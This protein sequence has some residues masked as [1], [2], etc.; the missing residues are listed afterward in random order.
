MAITGNKLICAGGKASPAWGD[1]AIWWDETVTRAAGVMLLGDF[2]ITDVTKNVQFGFDVNTASTIS[3]GVYIKTDYYRDKDNQTNL[4]SVTDATEYRFCVALTATGAHFFIRDAGTWH[5]LGHW[6]SDSNA[7]LY[8]RIANYDAAWS[9]DNIVVPSNIN[10]LPAPTLS[11]GFGSAFGTSDGLGHAEGVAG[12]VGSG[13]SGVTWVEPGSSAWAISTGEATNTPPGGGELLTDGDMEDDPAT[14]WTAQNDAVLNNFAEER[15]GGAGAQSLEVEKGAGGG[16]SPRAVQETGV[17]ANGLWIVLTGYRRNIDADAARFNIYDG[18]V[19]SAVGA[20]ET[21]TSWAFNALTQASINTGAPLAGLY[22][23][24]SGADGTSGLFDDVSTQQLSVVDCIA[25]YDYGAA[26]V[27]VSVDLTIPYDT[28]AGLI[29]NLDSTSNPQ[30]YVLVT[31][32]GTTGDDVE[33]WKCVGGTLS[34]VSTTAAS[35]SAGA[36]LRARRD[37]NSVWVYY[38]DAYITKATI[39][40]AGIVSGTIHGMFST[41]VANT[42]DNFTLYGEG[43]NSEYS[44]LDRFSQ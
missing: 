24:A 40:D 8:V 21:G 27:Q 36:T 19:G 9:A 1:P 11:D 39:S 31:H 28:H 43:G 5:Y 33:V 29:L 32:N 6:G 23:D 38:N 35:Y 41:Y 13:G 26:N 22:V 10:W 4:Y 20:S 18:A 15:T 17:V 37:G 14:N 34:R 42:L 30:N 25:A 16:T 3:N 44:N 12:S 7:T 2:N